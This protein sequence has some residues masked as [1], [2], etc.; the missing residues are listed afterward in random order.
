[1]NSKS[2]TRTFK[3]IVS[4]GTEQCYIKNDKGMIVVVEEMSKMSD[5]LSDFNKKKVKVEIT[6]KI[7]EI[8]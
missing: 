1:M 7:E 3:G 5:E 6:I 8:E 2:V 4:K